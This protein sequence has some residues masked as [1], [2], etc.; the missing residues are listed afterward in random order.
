MS[1]VDTPAAE[2]DRK[3]GKPVAQLAEWLECLRDG[4]VAD[5]RAL[6]ALLLNAWPYLDGADEQAMAARK[7]HRIEDPVWHA[8]H[9]TFVI[10]RHGAANN[11]SSRAELQHWQVDPRQRVA[12]IIARRTRQLRPNAARFDVKPIARELAALIRR[13]ARDERL[14]WR[15]DGLAVKVDLGQILPPAVAQTT[16]GRRRRFYTALDHE[17]AGYMRRGVWYSPPQ[18]GNAEED[19]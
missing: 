13:R 11:G 5:R 19:Q 17:L 6:L 1:A 8:P 4:P 3:H 2:V 15:S 10:E 16:T 7:L 12:E 9:L 18:Q 14:T